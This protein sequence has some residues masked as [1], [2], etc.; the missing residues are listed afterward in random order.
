MALLKINN[1]IKII[2]LLTHFIENN[3]KVMKIFVIS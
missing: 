2:N 3:I 1:I